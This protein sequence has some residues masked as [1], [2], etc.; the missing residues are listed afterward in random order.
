MLTLQTFTTC[1]PGTQ[2]DPA[3][4]RRQLQEAARCSE[5]AG[6]EG[7]L[8]VTDNAQPDP[9]LVSQLVIEATARLSPLVAVQPA[10]MHP[11]SVAKMVSTLAGLHGRRVHLNLVAGG[12]KNDLA[13]LNDQTPHDERYARL[14][15]YAA[16]LQG[17]L[18]SPQALSFEGRYYKVA[19]L[20]LVPAMPAEL[21]PGFFVSGSSAAGMETARALRA[22]AVEYPKPPAEQPAVEDDLPRGMRIGIIAR[23][24]EEEAWAAALARY[25][26][27]RK[28][29]LAHELAMKVSDSVWHRQLSA[30]AR[31]TAPESKGPARPSYWLVPFQNYKA[32]CPF[33]V[34]SYGRV[35]EEV[36]R[37]AAAG[38]RSF[39][40]DAPAERDELRHIGAVLERAARHRLAA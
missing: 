17:L 23:A 16:I 14:L 20:K 34:G 38:Y 2:A 37:Y 7:M 1:P 5:E 40:L 31:E 3:S 24:S 13:A 29:Q 26:E 27:D 25:P 11:Y 10:Y 21:M 12:F 36:A 33:L 15:E 32:V 22:T 8:V 30:L 19:N 28:G 6:C 4:W 18:G 35:A 9:W 39:I